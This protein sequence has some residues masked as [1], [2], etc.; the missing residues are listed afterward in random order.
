MDGTPDPS[1]GLFF[2]IRCF[3]LGTGFPRQRTAS[4]RTLISPPR[5]PVSLPPPNRNPP[6]NRSR[7]QVPILHPKES[8]HSTIPITR[9]GF[10]FLACPAPINGTDAQTPLRTLALPVFCSSGTSPSLFLLP[11]TDSVSRGG[12]SGHLDTSSGPV[13]LGQF[14]RPHPGSYT[15]LWDVRL[16]TLPPF[17]WWWFGVGGGCGQTHTLHI[18]YHTCVPT[19]RLSAGPHPHPP[20]RPT[21]PPCLHGP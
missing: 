19:T 8:V 15:R 18:P 21:H 16:R 10:E 12:C 1:A 11:G 7:I 6:L 2:F 9:P 13:G 17:S 3:N 14:S 5:Y 20:W 4:L